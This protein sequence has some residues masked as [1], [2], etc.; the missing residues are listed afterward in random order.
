VVLQ[1]AA[2][3]LV[4]GYYRMPAIHAALSRLVD[5]RNEAG[6]GLGIASTAFFGGM[7]PFLYIR[8]ARPGG[9][10]PRYGWAQGLSL[11]AFWGY[12]GLEVDLW[13]RLQAHVIGSGHDAATIA[14]K[15]FLDQFVYCPAFAIPVTAAVYGAVETAPDWGLLRADFRAPAWYRRRVLPVLVSNVVVWVPAVAVIYSLPTPLQLPLQNIVL[16]FYTL[17]VAHQTRRDLPAG[18]GA[19]APQAAGRFL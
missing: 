15:V 19:A 9:A 10:A 6:V 4:L 7:L 17:I 12:K 2:L 14:I 13:Y 3:V 11:T 5:I 8:L 1:V 18:Q 16:C